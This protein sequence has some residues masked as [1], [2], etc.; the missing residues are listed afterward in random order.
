ER[1]IR[2]QTLAN[3]ERYIT[4]EL[5]ELEDKVLSSEEKLFYLE[6]QLFN[7]LIKKLSQAINTVLEVAGF[8]G[9]IDVLSNYAHNAHKYSYVRPILKNDSSFTIINGRH[10]VVEK[11]VKKFTANNTDFNKKNIK[12][13][14]GPNMSG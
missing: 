14:T 7:N 4:T 11:L 10:P 12:I 5:K 13:I 8:V 2:K 9:V 6:N 3:A 1:Y